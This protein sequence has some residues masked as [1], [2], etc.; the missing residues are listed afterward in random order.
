MTV[1]HG[2]KAFVWRT[3]FLK[4][5]SSLWYYKIEKTYDRTLIFDFC[6]L[7]QPFESYCF[8]QVLHKFLI[9][10]LITVLFIGKNTWSHCNRRKHSAKAKYS[11]KIS[12]VN[13]DMSKP[14][15]LLW[16]YFCFC[17]KLCKN[18]RAHRNLLS[19]NIWFKSAD[20]ANIFLPI[21]CTQLAKIKHLLFFWISKS[22]SYIAVILFNLKRRPAKY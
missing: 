2:F 15:W 13:Y 14:G 19:P 17:S 9:A 18:L 7:F 8:T 4:V 22:D 12:F 6:S 11:I 3:S 5:S 16:Q 1:H 21:E 10:F 20:I